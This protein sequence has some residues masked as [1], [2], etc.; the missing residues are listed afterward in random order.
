MKIPYF[1]STRSYVAEHHTGYRPVLL[2]DLHTT[3]TSKFIAR[4]PTVTNIKMRGHPLTHPTPHAYSLS[5]H[6]T[7]SIFLCQNLVQKFVQSASNASR[8]CTLSGANATLNRQHC[9]SKFSL[10][11]TKNHQLVLAFVIICQRWLIL[12]SIKIYPFSVKL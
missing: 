6:L 3:T 7:S 5:I 2:H 4:S 8:I 1:I 12:C 11:Y 9:A 10:L